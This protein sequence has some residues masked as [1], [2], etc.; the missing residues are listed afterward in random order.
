MIR[1]LLIETDHLIA[2][3]VADFLRA[4]GYEVVWHKD[5]QSAIES[6]DKHH[7]DVVVMDLVLSAHNGVEFL[8]ELRSY[9]EW[10]KL[11]VIIFSNVAQTDL[12]A[13]HQGLEHLDILAYHHKPITSLRQLA[14]SVKVANQLTRI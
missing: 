12:E 3:N 10:H 13:V 9:P 1:I 8:Y 11:P 2:A 6:T 4:E 7:P 5:P 14:K